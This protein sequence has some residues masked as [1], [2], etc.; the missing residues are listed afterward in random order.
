MSLLDLLFLDEPQ[1]GLV[2]TAV[3]QWCSEHGYDLSDEEGER[4]VVAAVALAQ[5]TNSG[6]PDFLEALRAEMA[7]LQPR[8]PTILVLEDEPFIALDMEQILQDAG[9]RVEARTSCADAISWLTS[10]TP[11]VAVLD[12]QLRDGN[13][14]DI[15]LILQDRDIPIVFCTGA[16]P[17]DIPAAFDQVIW[18]PKPFGERQFLNAVRQ[19][20]SIGDPA[21]GENA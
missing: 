20:L 9:F 19:G 14:T 2:I 3:R 15:A 16:D 4:A 6:G 5:F 18:L 21:L 1:A 17:G 10:H 13:C 8:A 7:S 12:F 11:S